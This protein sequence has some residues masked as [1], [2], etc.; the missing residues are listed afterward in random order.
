MISFVKRFFLP[1]SNRIL[2][3]PDPIPRRD[4]EEQTRLPPKIADRDFS[5]LEK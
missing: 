3:F 4:I 5:R 2:C 1:S